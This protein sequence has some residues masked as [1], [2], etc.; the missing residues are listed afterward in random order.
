MPPVLRRVPQ[1]AARLTEADHALLVELLELPTAGPLETGGGHP[2]RL[3]EAQE[4]YA[5]AATELGFEVVHHAPADPSCL[6][7]DD[8]PRVLK[9][10][11]D[12]L[13][14]FLECQPSLVLRLGPLLPRERTVMFNVH[15]DTVFGDD[16]V[17]FDGARFHGRGA[18]DAKG[19]AVALL[20][21]IRAA[22]ESTPAIGSRTGVLIQAVAGE[23]GGAMGCIGTRP[24]VEMGYVGRLNVF[25]EPTGGRVLTRST[26]AMTA[27]IEARGLDA[28]DD[29][30][31][32]GHNATVLLGFLAQRLATEVP[33]HA[34]DGQ[35][36]IAGLRTG[37][38]HNKVYG[39]GQLLL[40]LSYGST[41]S[42][43]HLE[44]VLH[45]AVQTGV[46]AF[47]EIFRDV[48]DFTLTAAEAEQVIRVEWLKRGL[49][50]LSGD[51]AWIRDLMM[52]DAGLPPWPDEP[53]FTCDAIWM[54]GVPDTSTAVFG[55][56]LLGPN[57]AHASG[58]FA[59]VAE[60]EAFA[61]DIARVLLSF[62]R[63]EIWS[64]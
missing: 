59:D 60:L 3:W 45:R 28:I 18:I 20:R 9:E 7:G 4:A 41:E 52:R 36:C 32:K 51:D 38:M 64:Q 2:V 57:K 40:N 22:Q 11:A 27:S 33:Q 63:N 47:R 61:R 15:L 16:P 23:E 21:G 13:P 31:G 34:T 17:R 42:A 19:P 55:P 44:D 58:E 12:I 24:L 53:A 54:H 6:A 26:A 46:V 14:D 10:S 1:E 30:P 39:S 29:D 62:T 37:P 50:A 49:P 35:V 48:R 8:V 56:G 25:C 5:K 43:R